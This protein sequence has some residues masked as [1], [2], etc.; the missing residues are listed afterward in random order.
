MQQERVSVSNVIKFAGAFIAFLIGSGFATGQEILQYYTSYG[1][2]G[3]MTAVVMFALF[4]YAG[5]SF[6]MAGYKQNFKKGSEIFQYYCGE[7]IGT[8]YDYFTVAFLFMSYVVMIAGAGATLSEHFGFS[9]AVGA[10]VMMVLAGGTVIMGLGSIVDIIGKIGPV[11]VVI[12]VTL[13]A[14]A[15]FKN[16]S[17]VMEGAALIDSGTVTLMK[18]GT[19][20][21]TSACS[22]V[23]FSMLWL[24][25]FLAALGKKANSG[26]EAI[27][28][29]SLGAVG[30]FA[31]TALLML[32]LLANVEA[33]AGT[34]IPSLVLATN[35]SP[36]LATAFSA[37]IFAGIYTTAVPLLWQVS[38]RFSEE[39]TRK[40]TLLTVALAI[41]GCFVGLA[42][43][44][45]KL[46]NII[47][48]INGYIG[49]I[50]MLFIFVK[51]IRM[52]MA[53]KKPAIGKVDFD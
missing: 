40:F 43:P 21:F 20:W 44:F 35:I 36:K 22:Y 6:I 24:A 37:I 48:G 46:V 9:K 42:L 10:V 41:L 5:G 29:T 34:Q 13:G 27:L 51:D 49:I 23:G 3:L 17:G 39:R 38:A 14:S 4:V 1:L 32:G 47:Y 52:F 12:S 15:I 30:F 11:I 45:S 7:K 53:A 28:G 2:K 26:R 19:N 50:L 18:A 16:P 33:V 31:G 25:A 8:V